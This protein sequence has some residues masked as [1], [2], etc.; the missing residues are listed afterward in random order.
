M[1]GNKH[2]FVD[3]MKKIHGLPIWERDRD[4]TQ[5]MPPLETAF[6]GFVRRYALRPADGEVDLMQSINDRRE[7]IEEIVRKNAL[8]ELKRVQIS[9]EVC[10][11]KSKEGEEPEYITIYTR[12]PVN[13]QCWSNQEFFHAVD[14]M[15]KTSSL[16]STVL[17]GNFSK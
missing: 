5:R 12:I 2:S 10:L 7:Q 3:Y 6:D 8:H 4:D 13:V 17:A 15:L 11:D 16:H 1:F 14:Q 9:A